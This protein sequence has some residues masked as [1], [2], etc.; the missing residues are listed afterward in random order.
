MLAGVTIVDPGLDLDRADVELEPDAVVHPFTVLRGRDEGRRGRRGRPARRRSRRRDRAGRASSGRSVTFAPA[1][2]SR[3]ARRRARSWRSRTRASARGPRCR[4]S[5]TSAT[6]TSARTRT[7][8]PGTSPRTSPTSPGSRRGGRRSAATSG[9]A[10]T[11]RSL[12]RSTIGDDA[13]IAA[14]SVDHRGCPARVARGF[15]R[16]RQVN[17][18]GLRAWKAATTELTPARARGVRRACPS[19]SPGTG[20]SAGRR[21]G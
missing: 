3:R 4:T 12:L 2:C 19:R 21:S 8:A 1:R 11:M 15:A 16:A 14:G 6:P 13:W 7:S 17:K 9:P 18:E 10:S 5:P 20:S